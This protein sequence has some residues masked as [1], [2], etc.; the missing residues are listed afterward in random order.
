MRKLSTAVL[1][2]GAV[3]GFIAAMLWR[4][5]ISVTCISKEETAKVISKQGI[6]IES[7][8]FGNFTA[9]PRAV[10]QLDHEPDVL[11]ITTK[12]TTLREAMKKADPNLLAG[13]IIVP[14]LNG[15]EHMQILRAHY[16]KR[17]VAGSISIEVSRRGVNKVVHGTP[18]AR[19][20]LA[21]DGDVP[22]DRLEEIAKMLSNAGIEAKVLKS[23]AAVLWEKLV[24]LNAIACTT[25]ASGHPLGFVKSDPWW[26]KQL[27]GCVH[28]GAAVA[29]AEG[30]K[31]DPK[32]VMAQ[33][34][35]LPDT[36]T[37]SMQRD[38]SAGREPEL[39][40][41]AGAVIRAGARHGIACP[42]I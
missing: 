37:T 1:G 36:L 23:E 40:A 24:R 31:T 32:T 6:Q 10:V 34:D 21:S 27:E 26:R 28:E 16:G 12:A 41:I 22:A 7:V 29:T 18:F 9:H 25:S 3:G 35:A 19:V 14:L 11:F 15:L 38:I 8:A 20:K 42:T 13:A 33:I 4:S 39:D 30:V 5:G 17:V 2:P